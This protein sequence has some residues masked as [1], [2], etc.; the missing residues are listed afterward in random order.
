MKESN[1]KRSKKSVKGEDVQP[2]LDNSIPGSKQLR[3]SCGLISVQKNL[4][5]LTAQLTSLAT[6]GTYFFVCHFPYNGIIR[7]SSSF[8]LD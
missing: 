8:L 1:D 6:G 4:T 2:Y 7:S 3:S 5:I